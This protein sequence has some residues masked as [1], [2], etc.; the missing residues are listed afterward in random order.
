MTK[1]YFLK[2]LVGIVLSAI[3][4]TSLYSCSKSDPNTE[5]PTDYTCDTD[6]STQ[7]I[8]FGV[9]SDVHQDYFYQV[10][11]RMQAFVNDMNA[12]QVDFII[13]LGDF[14]FPKSANDKFL[15]VWNSFKGA[16]YHVIGNHDCEISSKNVFMDYVDYPSTK[17]YYSFDIGGYHFIVL[18][19]NFGKKDGVLIPFDHNKGDGFDNTG[20]FDD[21][22]YDWLE[23]DLTATNKRTIIFSH[24]PIY[25]GVHN[26]DRFNSFVMKQN[27]LYRKVVA[28]FSG[29][30]HEDWMIEFNR[31]KHC[32]INSMCFYYGGAK[33]YNESRYSAEVYKA[34]PVMKS[35]FPY[36][37]PLFAIVEL[38]PVTG[39]VNIIGKNT[40]FV[41]PTPV[42]LGFSSK[43]SS[44][45]S[46]KNFKY[47]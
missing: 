7:I 2:K 1:K 15:S 46:N 29:H 17:P 36:T 39:S 27:Q 16:K 21:E 45:I 22:E 38:N 35:M 34:Y 6:T 14:C 40:T 37:D 23:K 43:I 32:Q 24:A 13:Q 8:R 33:A 18:D 25:N 3:L 4:L 5:T 11:P 30:N 28:A 31:V 26:A 10:V 47:K 41:P 12:E 9:C 19:T 44:T 20:Y 42:E